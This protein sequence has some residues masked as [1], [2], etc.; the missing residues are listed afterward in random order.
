MGRGFTWCGGGWLFVDLRVY[1]LICS[2][3]RVSSVTFVVFESFL[4]IPPPKVWFTCGRVGLNFGRVGLTS[5]PV[6]YT[7][8]PVGF[9]LY[10]VRVALDFWGSD[11]N[12]C[13]Y[14]FFLCPNENYESFR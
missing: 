10:E 9:T 12:G 6:G 3:L 13:G 4:L 8:G 11:L 1:S 14:V 5:G 7:F 2:D